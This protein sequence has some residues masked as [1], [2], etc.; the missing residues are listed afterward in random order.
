MDFQERTQVQAQD[1]GQSISFPTQK[2]VPTALD[3]FRPNFIDGSNGCNFLVKLGLNIKLQRQEKICEYATVLHKFDI[4]V[5]KFAPARNH[6]TLYHLQTKYLYP[7][8]NKCF[9]YPL[10][11]TAQGPR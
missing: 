2:R 9:Y 1:G 8:E 6:R 3:E 10:V 5:C 4:L 7:I 11:C